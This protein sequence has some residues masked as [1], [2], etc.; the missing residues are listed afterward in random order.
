MYRARVEGVERLLYKHRWMWRV[1]SGLILL[2][3]AAALVAHKI[4]SPSQNLCILAS[5]HGP[6]Y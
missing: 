3:G 5:Y 6:P 1:W 4:L 2:M